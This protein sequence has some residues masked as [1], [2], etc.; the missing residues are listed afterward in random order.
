MVY[1]IV[2][3]TFPRDLEH[4]SSNLSILVELKEKANSKR[5][6]RSKVIRHEYHYHKVVHLI[7]NEHKLTVFL[8]EKKV[9]ML[10]ER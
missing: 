4:P 7:A 8:A 3:T 6:D 5:L 2:L 10:Y 9:T 1:E